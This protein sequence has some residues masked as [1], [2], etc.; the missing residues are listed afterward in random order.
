MKTPAWIIVNTPC[1]VQNLLG[2]E[3]LENYEDLMK[4]LLKIILWILTSMVVMVKQP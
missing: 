3:E 2:E 1:L 4:W